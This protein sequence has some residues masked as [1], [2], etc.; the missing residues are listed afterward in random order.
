MVTL[1]ISFFN[2]TGGRSPLAHTNNTLRTRAPF[3]NVP[4][5]LPPAARTSTRPL[6]M[7][8]VKYAALDS[9]CLVGIFEEMLIERGRQLVA[10]GGGGGDGA[11]GENPH[12]WW[13]KFLTSSGDGLRRNGR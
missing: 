11:H 13:T 8:Q 10:D 5:L 1:K 6:S 9:H 4:M 2:R 7:D 12:A 3:P